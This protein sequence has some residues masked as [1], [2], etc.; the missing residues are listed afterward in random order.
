MIVTPPDLESWLCDY[1]RTL[2]PDITG[3]QVDNVVPDDYRG[4]YPL[5]RVR[6]D[7]GARTGLVTFDRSIGVS[8]YMGAKLDTKPG[9]DLARR[10]MGMLMDSETLVLLPASPICSIDNDGCTGP[11]ATTDEH[12]TAVAYFTVEYSVAGVEYTA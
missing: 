8:V 5:I 10:L 3:L 6:D 11:Y 4:E 1:I 9:M 7:S 12:D 2:L